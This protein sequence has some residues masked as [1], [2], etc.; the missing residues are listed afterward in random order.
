MKA[1]E[2]SQLLKFISQLCPI[3]ISIG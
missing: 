2:R 1:V 3:R